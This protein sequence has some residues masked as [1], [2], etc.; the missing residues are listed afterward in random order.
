MIGNTQ[1]N[2]LWPSQFY[3]IDKEAGPQNGGV[4]CPKPHSSQVAG[5]RIPAHACL[6]L[7]PT[8]AHVL[9]LKSPVC[10]VKALT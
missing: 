4:T 6:I 8:P 2:K 5:A 10:S 7:R 1:D 3:V 9:L